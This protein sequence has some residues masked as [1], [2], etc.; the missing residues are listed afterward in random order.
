MKARNWVVG[1]IVFFA[2]IGIVARLLTNPM[3]LLTQILFVLLFIAGVFF[4]FRFFTRKSSY[5]SN[6]NNAFAKAARQ[7][8]KRIKK[9]KN[10]STTAVSARKKTFRKKSNAHLTVIEGKKGKKDKKKN[11]AI[12]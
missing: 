11:R 2:A 1:A 3:G 4:L 10:A 5:Q 8:K 7:S 12:F 9:K 6:Q